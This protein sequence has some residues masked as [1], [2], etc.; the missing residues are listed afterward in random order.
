MGLGDAEGSAEEEGW[1]GAAEVGSAD[2]EAGISGV[3][4]SI[5]GTI[6]VDGTRY[7]QV[8]ENENDEKFIVDMDDR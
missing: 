6:A 3:E 7:V 8:V 5:V 2:D 1:V 4:G